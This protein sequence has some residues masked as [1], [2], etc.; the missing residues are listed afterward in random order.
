[1]GEARLPLSFSKS[2]SEAKEGKKEP[3][4]FL[5]AGETQALSFCWFLCTLE[6]GQ[7]RL[8][9][10]DSLFIALKYISED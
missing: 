10:E 5:P 9:F 4:P 2:L 7:G 6:K 3:G 1:M 8:D